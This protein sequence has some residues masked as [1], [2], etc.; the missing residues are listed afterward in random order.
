MT[1]T[2]AAATPAI[3][4]IHAGACSFACSA[5]QS[6]K[7]LNGRLCPGLKNSTPPSRSALGGV[8]SQCLSFQR[9]HQLMRS[10]YSVVGP[11]IV[12]NSPHRPA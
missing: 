9:S 4:P 11:A 7:R 8:L 5:A 10:P 12:T 2:T 1:A 3:A 6:A